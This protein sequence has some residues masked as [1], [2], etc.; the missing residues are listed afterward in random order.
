MRQD[1]SLLRHSA[2][3][4]RTRSTACVPLTTSRSGSGRPPPTAAE[5]PRRRGR[6]GGAADDADRHASIDALLD[7]APRLRAIANY[8]VGYD[9]IDLE[10]ARSAGDPG[11]QHARRPHRDDRRPRVRAAA[12]RRA[13]TAR[14]DRSR[15]GA[16]RGEHGSRT[17]YL[18]FEVH[19][20]TLG[21]IGMGRIGR[22]GRAASRGLR[23]ER[24]PRGRVTRSRLALAAA[25]SG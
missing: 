6:R 11:R 2:A 25:A 15:C 3:A 8:A 20:A 14:R 5:L 22:G 9:N 23:D 7:H 17:A 16:A 13:Q 12:R 1:G 21:I 4:R 19:G 18:G 24:D 10:A